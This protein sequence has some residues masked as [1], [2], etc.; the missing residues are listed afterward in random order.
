MARGKNK[1]KGKATRTIKRFGDPG[2]RSLFGAGMMPEGQGTGAI[3]NTDFAASLGKMIGYWPHIEDRMIFIL[4]S[5]IGSHDQE[6]PSQQIF[7]AIVSQDGRIK[8][9]RAILEQSPINRNKGAIYDAIIDEFESLNKARNNY[10]H[11]LWWTHESGRMFLH[12]ASTSE[13]GFFHQREVTL[14]EMNGV[15]VRM[16]KLW[17]RIINLQIGL[18]DPPSPGPVKPD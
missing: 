6:I 4:R 7:R 5:L 1:A 18:I 3:T 2:Q 13:T 14:D 8:M 10:V 11:G 15:I 16:A 17:R 12:P 9:M